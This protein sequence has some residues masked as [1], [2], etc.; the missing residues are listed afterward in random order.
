MQSMAEAVASLPL[1]ISSISRDRLSPDATHSRASLD[2]WDLLSPFSQ[3]ESTL[4]PGDDAAAGGSIT[5]SHLRL[6]GLHC[7]AC[8]GDIE[9]ALLRSEGVLGAEVN[10]ASQLARVRWDASRVRIAE[11][12]AVVEAAGYGAAPD[13]ARSARELRERERRD[14]IWRLFVAAFLSMQVMMLA[15]PSYVAAEGDITP[16]LQRLLAWGQWVLSVPVLVFGAGPFLAGA[17]RSVKRRS[18]GMDVPVSLG[19][20]TTF[21]VSSAAAFD[22]QGIFGSELY[23]ESLTMFVAFLWLGRWLEMRARHR[24]AE[25]LEASLQ[26]LP[27]IA[28]RVLHGGALEEV[29]A[30]RLRSG[31]RVRV[32]AGATVPADG[33]LASSSAAVAEALLTGESLAVSKSRGDPLLA[34]SV[35]A[36]APFEM[37]VT[38]AGSDTRQAAIAALMRDALACRPDV[39]RLADR[40]AG[41]FLW[42]VLLLALLGGVVWAWI[43]PSRVVWVVVSV[44]IVTCPCALSLATPATWVASASG[45]AQRGILLR[46][47][48]ALQSACALQR[49]FVDKTGTLTQSTPQLQGVEPAVGKGNVPVVDASVSTN[50]AMELAKWSAHPLTKA[51]REQLPGFKR[52]FDLSSPTLDMIGIEEIPGK[53]L[54]ARDSTGRLWRLGSAA[55]AA[56]GDG[57]DTAPNANGARLVLALDGQNLLSFTFAEALRPDARRA[58]E[59]L[60]ARGVELS[61]LSGDA[62]ARAQHVAHALGILDVRS[63]ATPERKLEQLREAQ[64]KGEHCGML[65]DGLNDS[66]VLGAADLSIAMGDGAALAQ[67]HADVVLISPRLVTLLD[68]VDSSRKTLRIVRQN[69]AWSAAYNAACIPAALLGWLP[70]WAAGL[71]MAASSVA[72]VLNAQRAA[73]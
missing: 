63:S 47:L 50:V 16:D 64:R 31:D 46:R 43:D 59:G 38:R 11:L 56:A 20:L 2:D 1:G 14:M 62:P 8:A 72:V 25:V 40:W 60:R 58:V 33:L 48:E 4:Q 12:M 53:G 54:Q 19:L 36:A 3:R 28:W 51:L 45:L 34:G 37:D 65:G 29:A 49:L 7:A 24:A 55:W 22:P 18:I 35:N 13:V 5:I 10:G 42:C 71:G 23:F 9:R 66:A 67:H 68:L 73:R 26:A 30:T 61:L 41:P 15:T 70:P 52:S 27:D 44:L 57:D 32:P 69:L 39:V 17:W 21:V 6:S